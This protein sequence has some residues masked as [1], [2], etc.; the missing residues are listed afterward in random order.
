MNNETNLSQHETISSNQLSIDQV[1]LN[2]L[3]DLKSDLKLSKQHQDQNQNQDQHQ[4][5]RSQLDQQIEK[6]IDEISF[7]NDTFHNET[8]TIDLST[9]SQRLEFDFLIRKRKIEEERQFAFKKKHDSIKIL[10]LVLSVDEALKNAQ[11]ILFEELKIATTEH[12][13]VQQL[14]NQIERA[15]VNLELTD[16]TSIIIDHQ[17]QTKKN[18][19]FASINLNKKIDKKT[20][21]CETMF[22]NFQQLEKKLEQ[23]MTKLM[24]ERFELKSNQTRSVLEISRN[25]TSNTTKTLANS[26]QT[27]SVLEISRNST[28][29][30]TK[31]LANSKQT[32]QTAK[33]SQTAKSSQISEKSRTNSQMNSSS[34]SSSI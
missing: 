32:H 26:K 7:D 4:L 17:T 8:N 23:K 28:S 13:I 30:T 1:S 29:N 25:S 21:Y 20:S 5:D 6:N 33:T 10:T 18:F 24:I 31:T 19:E 9:S 11:K 3:N 22:E 16:E 34:T 2:H 14:I 12:V 15:R 27:R